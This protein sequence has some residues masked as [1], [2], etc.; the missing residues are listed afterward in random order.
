MPPAV[1]VIRID[2]DPGE[3]DQS[4][5]PSIA[6]EADAHEAAVALLEAVEAGQPPTA[7]VVASRTDAARALGS[8]VA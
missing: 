2:V 6:I 3:L 7:G 4:V 5:K 1:T 8:A